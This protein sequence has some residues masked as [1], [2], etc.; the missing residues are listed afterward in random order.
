[1]AEPMLHIHVIDELR[2]GGAQTHLIT[3]LREVRRRDIKHRV[4]TL[5]G[6]GELS[7]HIRK[8]GIP[9]DV[10]DIRNHLKKRRFLAAVDELK[11]LFQ[12]WRPDLVEAHLTWSRL[13][14]LYAAARCGVPRRI[15]FEQGD[16]YMNSWKFRLA[17]FLMQIYAQHIVVCSEAL[18]DWSHSTHGI[19]RSRLRV[20]HNCV[21]LTRFWPTGTPAHSFHFAGNPTV[22]ATV[23]TLG[24]GVNKRVDIS[25]RALACARG[26]GAN[27]ALVICGD[28]EQRPDLERLAADLKIT[29][30]V[31]F[32]GTCSD[33][34]SVLRA[35]DAFC[36]A[37]PWEPFG[38]VAIE[39]MA[40]GLPVILPKSGGIQEILQ[41]GDGG[42]LYEAVNH[43]ALAR[44]MVE[45]ASNPKLRREMGD[46]GRKN[47]EQNF[48]SDYYMQ[49]LYELYGLD[50]ASEEQ[51][52]VGGY[53]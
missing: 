23:G 9:V 24:L 45:L 15:G 41:D 42:L 51:K 50:S 31:R 43:E 27:I 3:M 22:F 6:D 12:K 36:H 44:S 28:G 19:S 35:C 46:A 32:L 53:A 14:A 20:L 8:L 5:F 17:N 13:L 1:M 18:G 21:D 25:I 38:I 39:A 29:A 52:G 10:L 30:H 40:I 11:E 2:V 47:V 34:P 4:V 26:N 49:R 37:A 7:A 48:S 33:V 16:L